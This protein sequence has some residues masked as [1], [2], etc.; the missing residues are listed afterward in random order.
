MR[1]ENGV[2]S[3]TQQYEQEVPVHT[4]AALDRLWTEVMEQQEGMALAL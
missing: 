4:A 1:S 2:A 3:S